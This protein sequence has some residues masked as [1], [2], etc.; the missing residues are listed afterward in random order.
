M[1]LDSEW[2]KSNPAS[3][4]ESEKSDYE[5][6]KRDKF[7]SIKNIS[8]MFISNLNKKQL[9][10]EFKKNDTASQWERLGIFSHLRKD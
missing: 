6:T 3:Q 7:I 4:R 5:R 1:L 9:N 10:S 2:K 8:I